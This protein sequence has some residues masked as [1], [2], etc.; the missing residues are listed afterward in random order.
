MEHG[1]GD[2]AVPYF[3]CV[4]FYERYT[5]LLGTENISIKLFENA[6]H[7]DPVFKTDENVFEFV[8]FFDRYIRQ[9]PPRDY[10]PLGTLGD[11]ETVV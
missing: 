2:H 4:R 5:Q 6:E 9:I 8:R 11:Y 10:F 7:S 1:T 3:Q